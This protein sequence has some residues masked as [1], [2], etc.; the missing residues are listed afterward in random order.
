MLI[1]LRPL[2]LSSALLLSLGLAGLATAENGDP[3]ERV[4]RLNHATGEVSYSPAGEDDWTR[5]MRNRPLIRGDRLW[6]DNDTHAELQVGSATIRL[7]ENTS[8]EIL[9]LD[10]QIAQVQVTQGTISL[11]VPRLER[12]QIYEIATPTLAF[13]IDRPG[14]YRIDVDPD[15]DQATIVVWEGAGEVYGANRTFQVGAGETVRFYDADLRD[16]EI[17]GLPRAD[18]FDRYDLE[19]NQRLDRSVSL[20]YVSPDLV[21]YSDLDDYGSWRPVRDHGTVWFPSRVDAGWAPY[22]DGHWIWQEPWGWTWIDHAPWGFAPSHYGRWLH[23]SGR[24]GWIPGP[25]RVRPVYAPALVVF[26]GGS[27]WSLSLGLGGGMSIGWFPLGPREVYQPSYRASRDYFTRINVNNTVINRTTINNTYNYYAGD[28][29]NVTEVNYVNRSVEGAVTAV[30]NEVFVNARPVRQAAIRVD[31]KALDSGEITRLAPIAPSARSVLGA[32]EAAKS[33]PSR[34]VLE[35]PVLARHAPPPEPRPFAARERQLQANPGRPEASR[36]QAPAAERDGKRAQGR[37][38]VRVIEQQRSAEPLSKS[39]SRGG[40]DRRTTGKQPS[41]QPRPPE[42][43]STPADRPEGRPDDR[44]RAAEPQGEPGRTEQPGRETQEPEAQRQNQRP[45]QRP[46]E[47]PAAVEQQPAT[48]GRADRPRQAAPRQPEPRPRQADTE[49]PSGTP[50]GADRPQQAA[51][52]QPES[53]PRQAD[54]EPPS[55]A[56]QDADRPRQAAPRQ[57]EPRP[58]QADTEPPSDAPQG[59][60]RQRVDESQPSDQRKRQV[61]RKERVD[62]QQ[63]EEQQRTEQQRIEQQRIEQQRIEQQRIEQQQQVEDRKQRQDAEPSRSEPP[64]GRKRVVGPDA[65]AKGAEKDAAEETDRAARERAAAEAAEERRRAR[66]Q[67]PD[68]TLPDDPLS[69]GR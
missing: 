51:P 55:G 19:R 1:S 8:F 67:L 16:Y 11:R 37:E 15:D 28:T 57:P 43:S 14:R 54:T 12:G 58:R 7:G 59:A 45:Q 3:S 22:R 44:R 4:I 20:R 2:L 69:I 32:A 52:R 29:I 63:M 23:V 35:R 64:S 21:G 65:P 39:G 13:A 30:P 18:A 6:T 33:R 68:P 17:Y 26:V 49:P 10:D 9:D 66:D 5:A 62:T 53:R 24:W 50:Q 47:R 48:T 40:D 41:A 61:D 42:R 38:N 25:R 31:R 34:K 60:D 36:D 27:G 46:E 56:P